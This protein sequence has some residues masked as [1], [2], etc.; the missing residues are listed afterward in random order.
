MPP[1]EPGTVVVTGTSLTD[2]YARVHEQYG[3]EAAIL[4]SRTAIRRQP[5]RLGT[6]T[7]VEVVVHPGGV[8]AP[9]RHEPAPAMS[10]RAL[11]AELTVEIERL[12][13]ALVSLRPAPVSPPS[14][15]EAPATFDPLG[16]ALVA[17]GATSTVVSRMLT[18]FT[19]ETGCDRSDRPA[20]LAWLEKDIPAVAGTWDDFRGWH[21]FIGEA[22]AGRTSLI[23]A[24]AARL[25]EHGLKTVLLQVLGDKPGE[26]RRLQIGAAEHGYDAAV[27]RNDHQLA[28]VQESLTAYD[29]VLLDLP[30]LHH[31]SM[32]AGGSIH[33]RLAASENIHRHLVVPLDADF[34]DLDVHAAAARTW[35]CDWTVLTRVDRSGRPAKILDLHERIPLPTALVGPNTA[36]AVVT[37]ATGGGLLDLMLAD[38]AA[39]RS[40]DRD[41]AATN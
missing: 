34:E 21:A 23:M 3:A 26:I 29:V 12:E 14:G 36:Q 7:V 28:K 13:S 8:D 24:T 35:T 16:E 1:V 20:A 41:S 4:E 10:E 6:D 19:S 37:I 22:G 15:S 39:G 31:E 38:G 11:F 30:E 25:R 5:G 40:G 27:I 9:P 32:I 18:R 33:R 17:G 2:A